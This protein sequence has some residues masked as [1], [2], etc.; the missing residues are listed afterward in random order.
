MSA[1]DHHQLVI[2]VNCQGKRKVQAGLGSNFVV[3]VKIG[4][5]YPHKCRDNTLSV[6]LSDPVIITVSDV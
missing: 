4:P 1:I 6:Y 2:G 3:A 5:T